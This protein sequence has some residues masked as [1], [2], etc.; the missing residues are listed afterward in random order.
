MAIL[1]LQ[2]LLNN[3]S[4]KNEVI[5]LN[6]LNTGIS[7]DRLLDIYPDLPKFKI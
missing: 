5:K 7:Y 1:K 6:L 3:K 2:D 4:A